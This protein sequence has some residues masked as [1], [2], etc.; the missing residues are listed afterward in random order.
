M[1]NQPEVVQYD[2]GVYQLEIADPVQGGV[3]GKSN[4][5]IL[6]L[7][8]RTAFLKDRT[9]KLVSGETIPPTVAPKNSPALTGTPTTPDVALGDRSGK[10]PN[11]KFVQDTINGIL[12]KDVA[13]GVNVTLTATEAGNGVLVF[14]GTLTANISVIVPATSKS[15]I[16]ANRTT[17]AFTLTLKTAAGTGILVTQ[18]RS[19]ELWCDATNVLQSTNDFRDAALTGAPTTP[20]P[21]LGDSS[22]QIANTEFVRAAADN[23]AIVYAI[24]FGG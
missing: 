20:T 11:T 9:D 5:P 8:N 19:A 15:W 4:A 14:T 3:G 24:V 17:G 18:G 16:V 12:N 10:I 23:S 1:A 7:A 13:G 21:A 2:E 22:Q 6:N